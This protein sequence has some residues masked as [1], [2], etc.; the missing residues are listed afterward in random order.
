[1]YHKIENKA[2]FVAD[3]H[4]NDY[5]N[6]FLIFLEK[7][8]NSEIKTTQLFLMGDMFDFLSEESFY[9]IQKNKK[10]IDLINQLSL[11]IEIFYFEGNHDYNLSSLFPKVVVFPRQKQPILF[12]H[13]NKKIAI[14][15]GDIYTNDSFYEFY[16][17]LVRNKAFLKFMNFIDIKSIISKTIYKKLANKKICRKIDN[18]EDIITKRI[19]N[20][21][22]DIIIEG[23][24]HQGNRYEISNK[25]YK[26]I[27]SLFCS[28][29]YV[30]FKDFKFTGV[31][32]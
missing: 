27:Q 3:A 12:E 21:K 22:S 24:F 9:F 26:N 2:I 5:R 7:V 16:S 31:K 10:L 1:M 20:Y 13:K 4:F 17:L 6:E 25:I 30:I 23:H 28:G 18:F 15:H 19:S 11:K 14:S 8:E 32:V 29:E